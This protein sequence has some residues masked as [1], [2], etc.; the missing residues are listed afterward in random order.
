MVSASVN[1]RSADGKSSC[2]L[3]RTLWVLLSRG[4]GTI[5]LLN[6]FLALT[7]LGVSS[8][9]DTLQ[10]H[11]VGRDKPHE[12]RREELVLLEPHPVGF[13][14][15]GLGVSGTEQ[16]LQHDPEAGSS[17]QSWPRSA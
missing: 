6:Y 15:Q 16:W 2:C 5:F 11:G 1:L 17:G 12:Q 9:I 13:I 8:S 7:F 4:S 14:V 3:N 10:V